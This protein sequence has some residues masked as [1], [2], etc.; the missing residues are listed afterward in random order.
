MDARPKL[1]TTCAQ[2]QGIEG[3]ATRQTDYNLH[4]VSNKTIVERIGQAGTIVRLAERLSFACGLVPIPALDMAAVAAIQLRMIR[5]LATH[6]GVDPAGGAGRP[7][8]TALIGALVPVSLGTTF[9]RSVFRHV[10]GLGPLLGTLSMPASLGAATRIVGLLVAHHFETGGT[11]E[12]FD[13]GSLVRPTTTTQQHAATAPQPAAK[14]SLPD[15]LTKIEGI[16]PKIAALLA[17][18]EIRTF[19]DL[20][21]SSPKKLQAILTRA[22]PHYRMHD[23]VPWL[24]QAELAAQGNWDQLDDLQRAHSVTD[25]DA[26]P[27]A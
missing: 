22:G 3:A 5:Q 18:A 19:A 24:G 20:A 7:L 14:A 12:D 1:A 6:Y 9:S 11:L 26:S 17:S 8:R 21:A 13:L 27:S 25:A 10:P 16:G 4:F 23:P 2:C 15:D